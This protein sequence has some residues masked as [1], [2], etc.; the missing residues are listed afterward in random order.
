MPKTTTT[1]TNNNPLMGRQQIYLVLGALASRDFATQ[2]KFK[3]TV[4]KRRKVMYA[5]GMDVENK[6]QDFNTFVE[7]AK[8]HLS[9]GHFSHEFIESINWLNFRNR[10]VWNAL[11]TINDWLQIVTEYE[12]PDC[13]CITELVD[14]AVSLEKKESAAR[15][16]GAHQ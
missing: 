3:K 7:Q 1:T 4:G 10:G 8:M 14:Y 11:K 2:A 5:E 6:D 12:G 16:K 13:P 9:K 15:A